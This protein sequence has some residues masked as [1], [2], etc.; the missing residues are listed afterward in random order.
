MFHAN[1]VSI[2]TYWSSFYFY[3]VVHIYF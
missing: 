2:L 1:L 3:I